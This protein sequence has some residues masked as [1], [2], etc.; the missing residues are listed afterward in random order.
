ML[1]SHFKSIQKAFLAK[2]ELAKN[3]YKDFRY[4]DIPSYAIN[5]LTPKKGYVLQQNIAF[6]LKARQRLDL[7]KSNKHHAK[8][9]LIVFV[10]GGAWTHGDKSSYK[11]LGE[12]FAKE[13]FDV[14]IVNY[15]LAPEYIFP[16]Y[17]DDI[18][19]ALNYLQ[20]N[21][22]KL[23]IS[24]ENT[25]LMGHS[26]GAFNVMSLMYQAQAYHNF[27]QAH[28]KAIFGISGPYHFDYK[29]D[30]IAQDAFD[31]SIPYAEVMPYYFV[32]KNH[33][34]H[35]LFLAANDL[36]VKDQNTLDMHQKL[37]EVGNHSEI[38]RIAK[39]GHKSI[40]GSV[41]SLFSRFFSTKSEILKRMN[42]VL[43]QS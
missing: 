22:E 9:P 34:K 20:Q 29:G 2:A 37:T 8:K 38:I 30:P 10:Y 13:G 26:A 17:V 12:A 19:L 43:D 25:M 28:I 32:D 23:K 5:G 6:G 33:V 7:Y 24:T 27:N 11:F 3:R 1:N 41:S 36:V 4:Y 40:I 31:Q 39:T 16:S 18:S 14:A 35:Y 42:E 15:H 21:A